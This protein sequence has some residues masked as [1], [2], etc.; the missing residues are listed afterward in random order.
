[1]EGF[2]GQ[3]LIKR[4]EEV[5]DRVDRALDAAWP[6]RK[7]EDYVREMRS[8]VKELEAIAAQ[9]RVEDFTRVE[10]SRTYR[11]LGSLY[12]DLDPALGKEM[13]SKAREAYEVA[14]ALLGGQTDELERAKLNFNYANTLRQLYP[15]DLQQLQDARDRFLAARKCFAI[16]APQYLSQVDAALVSVENLLRIAPLANTVERNIRDMKALEQELARG[17]NVS[18]IGKK[19]QEVMKREGGVAGLTGRLKGIADGL[20]PEQKK[21]KRFADIQ[22]QIEALIQ[23]ILGKGSLGREEGEI[24]SLLRDRLDSEIK[25]GRV[26]DD[27]AETLRGVLEHLGKV[28]SGDET[29]VQAMLNKLQEMRE[30]AQSR[31]ETLHYLSHGID[32]PPAGSRAAAL[33]ELC[34]QLRRFLIE[35]MNRSGK[36]EEESKEALDLSVRA[37]RV[38]RRIYEAGG[39]DARALNIE[40]DELRP[41]ALAVRTFSGRI[42]PMPAR[43]IWHSAKV[44]VDTNAVFYS[45]STK[46]KS[47][48]AA[49]CGGL[50]LNIIPEPRGESYANARWKQLQQAMTAIFD[51]RSN[52]GPELAAVTYEFGIALTLGKPVV[53]LVAEDQTLPFDVDVDPV[54]L[55]GDKGDVGRIASAI[56]QSLIWVYPRPRSEP[57]RNTLEYIL[58]KYPQPQENVYADQ[59]LRMLS[60]IRKEPDPLTVTRTAAKFFDYLNDGET[61]LIQPVWSPVYPEENQ[62][63]LFH[64]MPFRPKWAD[65]VANATRK[66]CKGNNF[67]YI[68]GDEVKEPNVI[69]SIWEEIARATHVL[70]DLTGF[71]AN[72]ALELGITHTLGR[73][74]LMVGQEKTIDLLFPSIQKFRVQ[75]YDIKRVEES[76]GKE[77]R[78]FISSK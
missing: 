30:F 27:R 72:V 69:R 44:S 2:M 35:E 1:M 58:S 51:L 64:V 32:R 56:D 57:Y 49:A 7:G 54:V 11:L 43:P 52:A 73:K 13:L 60:E 21:D 42:H 25:Q 55:S 68:R 10:Q 61:M 66:I 29:D 50:G 46:L 40:K 23:Q 77:V 74:V 71:N 12:A 39:D 4:R 22:Q 9:M 16:Q 37:S 5:M 14:E 63:R 33:V 67:T 15:N 78:K 38:D 36:G 17:G 47:P 75:S 62:P 59:T 70:V 3:D 28:L 26:E 6:E 20:P 48:V 76:L 24:L 53:I 45:G 41:L 19:V 18:E 31:F 8:A 34:W 65:A